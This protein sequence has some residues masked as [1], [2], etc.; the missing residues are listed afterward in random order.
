MFHPQQN[1]VKR[2]LFLISI[3]CAPILCQRTNFSTRDFKCYTSFTPHIIKGD[4]D[5]NTKIKGPSKFTWTPW[6]ATLNVH[7]LNCKKI[8]KLS[9][10]YIFTTTN[11]MWNMVMMLIVHWLK[12]K[13]SLLCKQG[14]QKEGQEGKNGH[15]P[16]LLL[17]LLPLKK[18]WN[19]VKQ[20]GQYCYSIIFTSICSGISSYFRQCVVQETARRDL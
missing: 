15:P 5:W 9:R 16:L 13:G 7:S 2:R 17:P 3:S 18:L 11:S 10:Y 1:E 8:K 6:N 4:V 20:K 14:N 19:S 12:H